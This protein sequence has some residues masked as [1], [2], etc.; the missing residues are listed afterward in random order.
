MYSPR[1]K[2]T[3]LHSFYIFSQHVYNTTFNIQ[4][5]LCVQSKAETTRKSFSIGYYITLQQANVNSFFTAKRRVHQLVRESFFRHTYII[6]L[7]L[8]RFYYSLSLSQWES[9]YHHVIFRCDNAPVPGCCISSFLSTIIK[10]TKYIFYLYCR[11]KY[12]N[13]LRVHVGGLYLHTYMYVHMYCVH[14][15]KYT[16]MS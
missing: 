13:S 3:L 5:E 6:I 12:I 7:F 9:L 16:V 14:L 2:I 1:F 8:Y 4:L 11:R 15:F 10:K